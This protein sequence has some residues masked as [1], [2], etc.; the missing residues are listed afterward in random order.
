MFGKV[1]NNQKEAGDGPFFKK[2][3]NFLTDLGA[4]GPA[5]TLIKYSSLNRD[6][7]HV[8]V[9]DFCQRVYIPNLQDG[10]LFDGPFIGSLPYLKPERFLK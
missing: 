4:D 10:E 7:R 6:L 3:N 5:N 2:A 9:A 8:D 1:E